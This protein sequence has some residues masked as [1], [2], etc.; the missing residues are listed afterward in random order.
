LNKGG[1]ESNAAQV[2]RQ[3]AASLRAGMLDDIRRRTINPTMLAYPDQKYEW[4]GA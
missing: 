3:E 2:L 1:A 4:G